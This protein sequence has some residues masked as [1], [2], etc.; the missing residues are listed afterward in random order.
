MERIN[1][2]CTILDFPTVD[3]I[4]GLLLF[5]IMLVMLPFWAQIKK[6]RTHHCKPHKLVSSG[7]RDINLSDLKRYDEGLLKYVKI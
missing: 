3:P 5:A 7:H 2:F 6:L 4:N 1:N